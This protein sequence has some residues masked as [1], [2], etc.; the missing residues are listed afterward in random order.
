LFLLSESCH[1]SDGDNSWD[2]ENAFENHF[3][4]RVASVLRPL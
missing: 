1:C 2:G 3:V 4:S